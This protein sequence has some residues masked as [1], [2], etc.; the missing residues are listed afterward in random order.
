MLEVDKEKQG[1]EMEFVGGGEKSEILSTAITKGFHEKV[2]FEQK[3]P[4]G[5]IT[6]LV[7]LLNV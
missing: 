6:W 3:D 2:T 4:A 1:M 7:I 5:V